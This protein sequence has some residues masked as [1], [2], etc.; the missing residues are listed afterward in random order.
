MQTTIWTYITPILSFAAFVALGVLLRRFKVL[1][2][3]DSKPLNK[4]ITTATLPA[5]IFTA[6]YG[7]EFSADV[8]RA[9]ACGWV[10]LPIM[11]GLGWALCK[12]LKL[13]RRMTGSVLLC[14][15]WANTGYM[16][17]PLTSAIFGSEYLPTSVFYDLFATMV[18]LVLVGVPLAAYYGTNEGKRPNPLRELVRMPAFWALGIAL[19]A[20]LVDLPPVLIEWIGTLGSIT[21]PLVM[22]SVGLSLAPKKLAQNPAL[23]VSI[24]VLRLLVA[25]LLIFLIGSLVLSGTA[26]H[27]VLVF[28]VSMPVMML[29]VVIAQRFKLDDGFVATMVFFTICLCALSVPL[30][31]MVLF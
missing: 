29:A 24:A 21:A 7:A 23:V 20:R 12:A 10:L 17:Y 6:I 5:F 28:E 16:G 25:P 2:T 11:L 1:K 13:S 3:E 4:L 19:L 15:A 8:I 18:S 30:I 9:V 14:V 27:Q 26:V 22:I 31:Q